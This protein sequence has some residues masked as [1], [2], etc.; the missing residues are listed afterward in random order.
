MSRHC[1]KRSR[2]GCEVFG[3][4]SGSGTDLSVNVDDTVSG[5]AMVAEEVL[6]A[7]ELLLEPETS[8]RGKEKIKC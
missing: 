3:K 4:T 7:V 8:A 2:E 5:L 6:E 1:G